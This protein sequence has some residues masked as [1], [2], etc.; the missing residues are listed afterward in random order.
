MWRIY[1]RLDQYRGTSL[2]QWYF[3]LNQFPSRREAI[4]YKNH[5]LKDFAY[6]W[7]GAKFKIRNTPLPEPLMSL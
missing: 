5:L 2:D 1:Y 7:A 6:F 4:R 3:V